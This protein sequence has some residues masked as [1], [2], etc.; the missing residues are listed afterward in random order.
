MTQAPVEPRLRWWEGV[1]SPGPLGYALALLL[2]APFLAALATALEML[3][4]QVPG[5]PPDAGG[6]F[7]GVLLFGWV[8]T[9]LIGPPGVLAVHLVTLRVRAQWAHVL[10]TALVGLAAGLL[11]V[12]AAEPLVALLALAVAAARAAVVP[13]VPGVRRRRAEWARRRAGARPVADFGAIG[14]AG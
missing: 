8:F 6:T 9:L 1:A 14:S 2:S 12:Q 5:D 3:G 7:L 13:L 10:V 4:E 11:V